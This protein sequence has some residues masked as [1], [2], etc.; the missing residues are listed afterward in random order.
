M[1]TTQSLKETSPMRRFSLVFL[2]ALAACVAC[3]EP[4]KDIN[5]VQPGYL[6]KSLFDDKVWYYRQ[7]ITEADP[8]QSTGFFV[9]LEADMEKI[10][11][12]IREDQLLAFRAHEGVPGIDEDETRPGADYRGEPI[13][14]FG[15]SS[16]FDIQRGYNTAT[17][18]QNNTIS[19]NSSDRAW[20]DRKY[21]RVAFDTAVG[22]PAD[23]GLYFGYLGLDSAKQVNHDQTYR[24]SPDQL[25]V[26]PGYIDF[27]TI[28][29]LG[30]D[31]ACGAIHGQWDA[32]TGG[33][34]RLRHSFWQVDDVEAARFEP[35]PYLDLVPIEDA[36]GKDLKTMYLP[37]PLKRLFQGSNRGEACTTSTECQ[38][39]LA[40]IDGQCGSCT[41][42]S[43]CAA[44]EACLRNIDDRHLE[45]APADNTAVCTV[46]FAEVACTD[47]LF[48]SMDNLFA[49]GY[50]DISDCD[51]ASYKQFERFG[52][53]R[54]ERPGYDRQTGSNRDEGRQFF[55][56]IHQIWQTAYNVE[57]DEQGNVLSKTLIPVAERKVRPIVYYINT[58]Y[59]DDLKAVTLAMADDWSN[60]MT[61]AVL[62]ARPGATKADLERE[63]SE[64]HAAN[65]DDTYWLPGDDKKEKRLFQIRETDCNPAG[66]VDYL[67][68]HAEFYPVVE[69]AFGA[70]PHQPYSA[71]TTGDEPTNFNSAAAASVNERLQTSQRGARD[72]VCAALRRASGDAH[73]V[74]AAGKR[75][76][77]EF[78]RIGDVRY[79]FIYWV[80]EQQPDGPLGYGPSS[81]DGENG[82]VISANAHV[83]GAALDNS[84]RN[85]VDVVRAMNGDMALD[86]LLEGQ[87]IRDWI[88]RPTSV[89][90]ENRPLSKATRA[91][92]DARKQAF[93]SGAGVQPVAAKFDASRLSREARS[94]MKS[95][96]PIANEQAFTSPGRE[97]LQA[98]MKDP[99]LM[100]RLGVGEYRKAFAGLMQ[101]SPSEELGE[102][103]SRMAAELAADPVAFGRRIDA[104]NEWL[105]KNKMDMTEMVD[106]ATIGL[107][108]QL[109]DK[110]PEEIYRI[111][112]E[113]IYRGVMLHEIGH[114]MGLT[115]NFEGSIDAMNYQDEYWKK[116]WDIAPGDNDG[117]GLDDRSVAQMPE[118][119]YSTIMDYHGRFHSDNKGLG[120]YDIGAMKA[121]YT[122]ITEVF[123]DDVN[124]P[125]TPD[126][127]LYLAYVYGNN[128]IPALLGDNIENIR[129]RKNVPVAEVIAARKAAIEANVQAAIASVSEE[130]VTFQAS[131]EVPYAYC[132]HA[133]LFRSRCKM[134]D[135]GATNLEVVKNSVQRYWEYYFFNSYRRGRSEWPFLQGYFSRQAGLMDD[136]T[137]T[138]R[139]YLYGNSDSLLGRDYLEA[140]L[141]ALNFVNQVIGTT[142]PGRHCLD[143]ARD[144]FVPD[145]GIMSCETSKDVPHGFGRPQ[146]LKFNDELTYQLDYIG[147]FFDKSAFSF[148]L[149]DDTTRFFNVTDFGDSRRFSINYYRLFRTEIVTMVRDMVTSYL[150]FGTNKTYGPIVTRDGGLEHPYLVDPATFGIG[151]TPEAIEKER[152]RVEPPVSLALMWRTLLLSAAYNTS[153]YDGQTD[154]LEYMLVYEK[155]SAEARTLSA[156]TTSIEYQDP[157]TGVVYVAPQVHD[158]PTSAGG[159][160]SITGTIL[161]AFNDYLTGV[162]EPAR[163]AASAGDAS[164]EQEAAFIR[165]ETR[166]A[167]F[168]DIIQ[169]MRYFR[170]QIERYFD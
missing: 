54:T 107:A 111:L 152:Y 59:P 45:I 76:V 102:E 39:E 118:Y 43:Q 121:A 83:Y 108:L 36:D 99:E 38:F 30:D 35:R 162:Y 137:Y 104:R 158:D 156:E 40:C 147:A 22:S 42:S 71:F 51:S 28:Y 46:P 161:A 123:A 69:A 84:T 64:W 106:E 97:R 133:Y 157:I 2:A 41:A 21:I 127:G 105:A 16:H 92:L 90:S 74:D 142:T 88:D 67:T 78:Q 125:L 77:F 136:L 34:V 14:S 115:H 20:R 113:E 119:T 1:N 79:S 101:R 165:A 52:L 66:V 23:F 55:A 87:N 25:V 128:A 24:F 144:V 155:D 130:G 6:D 26:E 93:L 141:L 138:I 75:D 61:E 135:Q 170:A 126:L 47:V 98:M 124:L 89:A 5:L 94:T 65:P 169:D 49:P 110:D 48:E 81:T 57:S 117:D 166:V 167:E 91:A 82:Q 17:G 70:N 68:A 145:D 120:K 56:N 100:E 151:E 143:Q 44:G 19:E 27:T 12:E 140:T 103:A 29:E 72:R 63:L 8:T 3:A 146:F 168:N 13:A 116:R 114:T 7:T 134:F 109:K 95:S 159:D 4:V 96:R 163:D 32:C 58:A 85:A 112:R 37:V 11:W 148:F 154:F 122:G 60:A 9:G 86:E 132:E 150:G 131:R 10:R 73:T 62:A 164:A 153:A 149:F 160:L 53:F 129:K 15:I 139:Y 50:Y 80:H 33:Q 31:Y 18:E